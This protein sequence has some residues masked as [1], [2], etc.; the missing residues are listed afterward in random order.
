MYHYFNYNWLL[1]PQG[2]W[3]CSLGAFP[4]RREMGFSKYLTIFAPIEK[5]IFLSIV[6]KKKTCYGLLGTN[7][8]LL[9]DP[10][11][12]WI[13]RKI[14]ENDKLRHYSY[15]YFCWKEFWGYPSAIDTHICTHT[16]TKQ[17]KKIR[18]KLFS[19]IYFSF[20]C[21]VLLHVLI[22]NSITEVQ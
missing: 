12:R 11:R 10:E 13:K 18:S 21:I 17:N 15:L 7:S 8:V 1:Y 22:A 16:S 19:Y 9:P 4:E 5:N 2:Y 6:C 14:S 3:K 20:P